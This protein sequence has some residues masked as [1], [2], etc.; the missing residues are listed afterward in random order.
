[1]SY[2]DQWPNEQAASLKMF[3]SYVLSTEKCNTGYTVNHKQP[4]LKCT[5]FLHHVTSIK[6]SRNRTK[7][8]SHKSACGGICNRDDVYIAKYIIK[9]MWAV[10]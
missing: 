3:L 2:N 5:Y 10:T 8:V 4:I 7:T 9:K 6:K 1:M